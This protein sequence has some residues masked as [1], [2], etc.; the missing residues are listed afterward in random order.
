M[1]NVSAHRQRQLD[2][3]R[4]TQEDLDRLSACRPIFEQVVE[5]VVDRFYSSIE[6]Y[7]EM[8]DL[9]N[10]VSNIERLKETQRVYWLSLASGVIDEPFIENRIKIG[11]VHSRIGLTTDW[12]LGTYMT[13][14]DISTQVMQRVIPERWS[15]IIHSLSKMFN[16]DSQLVLEA[17]NQS[18]QAKIQTLADERS[19]MLTT[20]TGAVEKLAG[21]MVELDEGAQS[22]AATAVSTSQSQDKAHEL[23]GELQVE[24]DGITEMG[25]LIRGISD[26]THLLGLNAAIEAARAG[27]NGRGFEVVANEVRKLAASSRTAMETIQRN[28]EE[29]EKKISAVQKE[30]EQ[31]SGEARN[32]AARSQELAVFVQMVEQ[33][34]KDLRELNT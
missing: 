20:V 9:I 14:L 11:L 32:Q 13:Y 6:Q 17:Y 1:I 19:E 33:V 25:T 27:E 4:I 23:L 30:S 16:L 31:T 21:L 29:I 3:T 8:M 10:R 12:Y 34:A 18:E 15:G 26:Q 28:L 7:P 5:E 2:Y 24:L 22:I